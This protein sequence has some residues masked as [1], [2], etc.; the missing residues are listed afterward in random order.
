LEGTADLGQWYFN[1][2]ELGRNDDPRFLGVRFLSSCAS[3]KPYGAPPSVV[4]SFDRAKALYIFFLVG[5]HQQ[6]LRT[7]SPET[8]IYISDHLPYT[9]VDHGVEFMMGLLLISGWLSSATWKNASWWDHMSKKVGRLAPPYIVAVVVTVPAVAILGTSWW[10]GLQFLLEIIT[11]GGWNPSL[12]FNSFNRPLWFISTLL[13]YHYVSPFYLRFIRQRNAAQLGTLYVGFYLLRQSIGLATLLALREIYGEDDLPQ[14]VRVIHLWSPT[15]VWVPAMGAILQQ[16]AVK[17][18][19]P[20]WTSHRVVWVMTDFTMLTTIGL[21]C[22]LPATGN[23]ILD[24]MIAYMNLVTG[25]FLTV[26]VV[27]MSV[28]AGSLWYVTTRTEE[29]RKLCGSLLS[30]SYPLYLMHWP[31]VLLMAKFGLFK[32][33]SWDS[34]LGASACSILLGA[35]IDTI[36]VGPFTR[37]FVR[38]INPKKSVGKDV[39]PSLRRSPNILSKSQIM[40]TDMP[41]DTTGLLAR[42]IALERS[43]YFAVNGGSALHAAHHPSESFNQDDLLDEVEHMFMGVGNMSSL[44]I[45]QQFTSNSRASGELLSGARTGRT[46]DGPLSRMSQTSQSMSDGDGSPTPT[47]Q[48]TARLGE[49]KSDI[50]HSI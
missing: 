7:S 35:L 23:V 36:A 39:R 48:C 32:R 10:Q 40:D 43:L 44:S 49:I 50:V 47:P 34:T 2:N 12:Q 45:R 37:H 30:A 38:W 20:K 4:E 6:F 19:I 29:L 9:T 41:E 1:S 26:L 14:Y 17:V 31:L 27:L 21:A 16:L 42:I 18:P 25:P 24:A 13:S 3:S 33:D 22:F 15:Q 46:S 5:F 8:S 28:D 11:L